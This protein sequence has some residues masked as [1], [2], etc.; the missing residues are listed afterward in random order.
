MSEATRTNLTRAQVLAAVCGFIG[1]LGCVA[2]AVVN[3]RQ[4]FISYLFGYLFWLGLALGCLGVAMLHHLTGGRWGFVI[5]RFLES[6]VFTGDAKPS[7]FLTDQGCIE[8]CWEDESGKAVQLEFR[9]GE[10]EFYVESQNSE[11][12]VPNSAVTDLARRLAR[13]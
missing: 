5:R 2:G 4:F 7:V 3:S 13:I 10:I 6:A 8:L 1:L 11:G 9:P 12:T